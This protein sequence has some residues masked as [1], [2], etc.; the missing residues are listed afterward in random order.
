MHSYNSGFALLD[1][2][3]HIKYCA[4]LLLIAAMLAGCA[5]SEPR[6]GSGSKEIP[7][8]EAKEQDWD[9]PPSSQPV[10]DAQPAPPV[11]V[12][13]AQPA[14]QPAPPV[15]RPVDKG[16]L[17]P[18]ERIG[19]PVMLEDLGEGNVTA[20]KDSTSIQ[21]LPV[22][23]AGEV[24]AISPSA[25]PAWAQTEQ[26]VATPIVEMRALPV[27][28][29]KPQPVAVA[30]APAKPATS[31]AKPIEQVI[32]AP[33]IQVNNQFLT[34][35]D[36]L[37]GAAA[38]LHALPANLNQ[39]TFRQQALRIIRQQIEG[40]I[41]EALV[42][43]EAEKRL[44]EGQMEAADRITDGILATKIAQAGGSQ[45]KLEA[46]LIQQGTDLQTVMEKERRTILVQGYLQLRFQ[47]AISVSRRML[48]NYY[49]RNR[50]E[51][52]APKKV[53]MQIIAAP[54]K[55]FF[56]TD[57]KLSNKDER[58]LA[59]SRA[60]QVID[61]AAAAIQ[62]GE[63]FTAVAKRLSRGPMAPRGGVWRPMTAGNFAQA[64]VEHVAF[65]LAQDQ[66]SD[67]I[68][69]GDG[70][71]IVKAILVEPGRITSFE[72]AQEQ[73]EIKLRDEQ[74]RKLR[75]DYFNRLG[76]SARILQSPQF[77]PFTVNQAGKK[78]WRR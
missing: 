11:A 43:A 31:P 28:P 27:S 34:V 25:P 49:R 55:R 57:E 75:D 62:A 2:T 59:T 3:M 68:E 1:K 45:Q 53:Q 6:W 48:W 14:A 12:Q 17:E 33:P 13:S 69:T 54:A 37:R 70:Y 42:Y 76:E 74:F 52:A 38:K 32:A 66:V 10:A 41:I 8:T 26:E 71:Y 77:L 16:E 30:P 24:E 64:N 29:P 19:K 50:S 47:S 7:V 9:T 46:I 18:F 65:S 20:S 39:Q 73:V 36:I 23:P 58:R 67:I 56:Q 15:A 40:Q 22:A 72:Q 60:R 78:Y 4:T 51:F 5:E 35:D 21:P 44:T 61:E 63:D